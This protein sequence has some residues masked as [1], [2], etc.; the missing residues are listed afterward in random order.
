[1]DRIDIAKQKYQLALRYK[2]DE[3]LAKNGLDLIRKEKGKTQTDNF[4]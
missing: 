4:F 1:M 2:P 3:V